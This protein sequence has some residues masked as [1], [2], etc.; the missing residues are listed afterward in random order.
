MSTAPEVAQ[1]SED[2]SASAVVRELA[3]DLRQPLSSIAAIAY[4][5]EMTIPAGQLQSQ[6]YMQRVQELVAQTN[7]I[8]EHAASLQREV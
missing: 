1:I 2:L 5:V 4:Y 3:N 6:H 8:L 7:L